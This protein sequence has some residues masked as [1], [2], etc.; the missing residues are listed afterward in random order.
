MPTHPMIDWLTGVHDHIEEMAGD[1]SDSKSAMY[2]TWEWIYEDTD[3][4]VDIDGSTNPDGYVTAGDIGGLIY[5]GS[6]DNTDTTY[7]HPVLM[8][9]REIEA[10]AARWFETF[11][12]DTV[13]ARVAAER[14][15]LQEWANA[16]AEPGEWMDRYQSALTS[17]VEW[18]AAGWAFMP[19]F[20]AEWGPAR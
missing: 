2:D 1:V 16:Q 6:T 11:D 20:L 4:A 14:G 12:P 5:L 9:V 18:V 17:A 3:E 10:S 19:G 7:T 8:G 13:M 15:L